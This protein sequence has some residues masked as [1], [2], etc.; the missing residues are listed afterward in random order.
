MIINVAVYSTTIRFP[1]SAPENVSLPQQTSQTSNSA[2]STMYGNWKRYGESPPDFSSIRFQNDDSK[3]STNVMREEHIEKLISRGILQF[4]L[5][6]DRA[7]SSEH[8]ADIDDKSN[9]IFSPLSIAAALALVMLGAA[10]KT[11]KE[12]ETVLGLGA[13][14]DLSATGDE[15]HY[16]FGRF[17]KQIEGY[18]DPVRSTHAAMAEAIFVQDGF[19]MKQRFTKLSKDIYGSEVLNL[20]FVRHSSEAR[21]VI[22]K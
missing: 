9:V 7:L 12:I 16:H 8:Y 2:N 22:N 14:V 3:E 18:P 5:Q 11:Y 20:D 19:L 15:L 4:A 6:L 17:I 21:D 1:S 10:G 13:G